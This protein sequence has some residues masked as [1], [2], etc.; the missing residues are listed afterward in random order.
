MLRIY[1]LFIDVYL[2]Y[3]GGMAMTTNS[4][5]LIVTPAAGDGE[6]SYGDNT[7]YYVDLSVN[8]PSTWQKIPLVDTFNAKYSVSS[9]YRLLIRFKNFFS[10]TH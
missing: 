2:N 6:G 7:V 9:N 3:S 4:S 10:S 5:R 8:E 1:A